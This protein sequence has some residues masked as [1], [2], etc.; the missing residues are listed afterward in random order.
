[1]D[2]ALLKYNKEKQL[3]TYAGAFRPLL[4]VRNNQVEEFSGS[5]FPIGFYGDVV[6]KFEQHKIELKEGDSVY[7]FSDGYVD[8]FGGEDGK[9]LN[10]K[11]FKELLLT[12]SEMEIDDQ[13]AFLEYAFNNWK[14]QEEQTDD[15]VVI[16]LKF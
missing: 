9:K 10:R 6:K 13:E 8:Q 12:I 15:I 16:G 2:V 3:L 5:R 14:Q 4:M 7:L 1:M 11:R